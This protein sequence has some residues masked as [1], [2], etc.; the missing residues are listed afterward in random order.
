ML[1]PNVNDTCDQLAAAYNNIIK[2]DALAFA[3]MNTLVGTLQPDPTWLGKIRNRIALLSSAGAQW[4]KNKSTIWSEVLSPFNNYYSLFS[5]F[6]AACGSLGD[7]AAAW[8]AML[9][10][11]SNQLSE[12][13]K[14]TDAAEAAFQIEVENIRN[15]ETLLSECLDTAWVEL[16]SEEQTMITLASEIGSLQKKLTDLESNLSATEI[17][18][19]KTYI[20]STLTIAYSVLSSAGTSIPYLSIAGLIYTVGDLAYN[21]IV[22]DSEIS[23]TINKIVALRNEVSEEAQAAAMTKAIIQLINDFD[24]KLLAVEQQL[25]SFSALWETEKVKVD[26]LISAINAGARPTEVISLITMPTA[27]A[28]W[29]Q[30]SDLVSAMVS[31]TCSGGSVSIITSDESNPIQAAA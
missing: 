10:Q 25:P 17:S 9:T 27:E 29:K 18:D 15:I 6:T 20:K 4:Q 13:S 1:A 31:A 8:N 3:S 23:D 30:F 19:G 24:K 7:D 22:T 28:S 12:A 11:L 16:A 14:T 21:M 5:G 26:Q 2:L